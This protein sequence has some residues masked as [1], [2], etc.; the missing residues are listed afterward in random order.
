RMQDP[1][2][3][4]PEVV[5]LSVLPGAPPRASVNPGAPPRDQP[6]LTIYSARMPD[7]LR[8]FGACLLSSLWSRPRPSRR[9]SA[10]R[11]AAPPCSFRGARGCTRTARAWRGRGAAGGGGPPGPD[12]EGPPHAVI[13]RA[14]QAPH[15]STPV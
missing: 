5:G 7:L 11:R 15:W 12:T 9:G 14:T 4:G 1:L 2:R 13:S 8:P 3:Q 10:R 6:T